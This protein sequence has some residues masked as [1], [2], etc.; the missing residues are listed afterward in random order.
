MDVSGHWSK[1]VMEGLAET[2]DREA[3]RFERR[4]PVLARTEP[5]F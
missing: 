2:T 3:I 4:A 5:I 1:I